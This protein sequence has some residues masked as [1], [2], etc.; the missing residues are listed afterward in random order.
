MPTERLVTHRIVKLLSCKAENGWSEKD[1]CSW[2]WHPR[3]RGL[4]LSN[5]VVHRGT[6]VL[7]KS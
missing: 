7:A 6:E 2:G 3:V 1:G 4:V 5:P